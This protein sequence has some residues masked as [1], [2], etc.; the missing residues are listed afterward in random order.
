[1]PGVDFRA[2]LRRLFQLLLLVLSIQLGGLGDALAYAAQGCNDDPGCCSDCPM[3]SGGDSPC[4]EKSGLGCPPGCRFCHC[5]QTGAVHLPDLQRAP[6]MLPARESGGG[7]G[8]R[9]IAAPRPPF[10][11]SVYRPPER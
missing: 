1:M 4:P 2:V 3:T 7:R 6:L 9:A 10:L 11:S 8:V 5:H